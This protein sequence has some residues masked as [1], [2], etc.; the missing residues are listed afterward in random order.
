M[1][2]YGTVFQP[3]SAVDFYMLW[4]CNLTT[5]SNALSN[6]SVKQLKKAIRL[7]EKMEVLQAKLDQLLG[8]SESAP[9]VKGKRGRKPK[10]HMSA[11]AKAKISA[12]AKKRW[13]KAKAA[14]K[15]RL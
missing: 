6:L 11:A 15:S 1:R 3:F 5:M 8:S 4:L 12:A 13:A 2:H 10:R 7:R 14:G 9:A